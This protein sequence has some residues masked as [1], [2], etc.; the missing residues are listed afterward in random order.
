MLKP[1]KRDY[2]IELGFETLFDGEWGAAAVRGFH[3][4][5]GTHDG[6]EIA[7][8][9]SYRVTRG[10]FSFAPSVGVA[11]KSRK[12]SDYYWGVHADEASPLIT[13]YHADDGFGWEAGMRASYYLTKD[14][15]LAMSANYERLQNSV[16]RSP[17]VKDDHVLGWFAGLAWTF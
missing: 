13:E 14:L 3:D 5:S 10:R 2:A 6:F 15:R 7:A 1:P 9:Y 8:D 11:Y 16:A 17:L 12:F 4:V